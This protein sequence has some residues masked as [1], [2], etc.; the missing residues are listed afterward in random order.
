MCRSLSLLFYVPCSLCPCSCILSETPQT[1]Q[2]F[3]KQAEDPTV[4]V[5]MYGAHLLVAGGTLRLYGCTY[6]YI[7]TYIHINMYR[8]THTHIPRYCTI[9][10]TDTFHVPSHTLTRARV[11]TGTWF[12]YQPYGNLYYNTIVVSGTPVRIM[13]HRSVHSYTRLTPPFSWL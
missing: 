5:R 3:Q 2:S 10:N 9:D 13:W 12:H 11:L 7:T 8:C 4:R 6:M 1:L